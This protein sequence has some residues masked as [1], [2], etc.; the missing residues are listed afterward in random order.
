MDERLRQMNL[1]KSRGVVGGTCPRPQYPPFS[2]PPPPP[3][4]PPGYPPQYLPPTVPP[5]NQNIIIQNCD[6]NDANQTITDYKQDQN[7]TNLSSQIYNVNESL[8]IISSKIPSSL[9]SFSDY[10]DIVTDT[11]L[12]STVDSIIKSKNEEFISRLGNL[13]EEINKLN[14]II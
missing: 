1:R 12:S 7:I 4:P 5:P 10:N 8:E 3:P 9:S 14:D 2:P 13:E 11:E 6:C